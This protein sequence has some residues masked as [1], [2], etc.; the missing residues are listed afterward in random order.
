MSEQDKNEIRLIIRDELNARFGNAFIANGTYS[1]AH[2]WYQDT[3]TTANQW[4]CR[5]CNLTWSEC[6]PCNTTLK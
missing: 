6:F 1:C 2:D 4:R 5:K 3:G